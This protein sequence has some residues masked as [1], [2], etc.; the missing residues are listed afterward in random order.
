M[1]TVLGATLLLMLGGNALTL[2][3]PGVASSESE[4]RAVMEALHRAALE[5]D[6]E[7]TAGL[8]TEEYVQTDISGHFEEK[9]E[10]LNTYARPL[11]TL[12]KSGKFH[13]DSYAERD[14]ETRLYDSTAIVMGVLD[15][16]GTG[17]RW[18]GPQLTW[19]AD[20]DAHPAL[21]LRFTRVFVR[22]DGR[23]LLAAIHNAA[24]PQPPTKSQ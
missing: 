16:K 18:S 11:A 17:A 15:L 24:V 19:V 4:L 22:R 14:V 5:G 1:R 21:V 7:K 12:I 3:Q 20:P 9:A 23:W 8:M 13:W 10:W 6:S 2:A